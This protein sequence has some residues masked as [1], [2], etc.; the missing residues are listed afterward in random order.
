MVRIKIILGSLGFIPFGLFTTLPWI[1]GEHIAEFSLSLLAIYGGVILSFLGGMI[2][3]WS[4]E[5]LNKKVLLLGVLFSLTGF[6]IIFLAQR[7]LL[8][9]LILNFIFFPLFYL[10]EKNNSTMFSDLD[11]QKLRLHLTTAVC[12]CY[13]LSFLNFL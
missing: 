13:L 5:F 6:V 2:W 1:L 9:A 8:F 3:G 11:Y 4:N 7:Y 12:G 10:F